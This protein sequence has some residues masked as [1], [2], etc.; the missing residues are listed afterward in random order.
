[1]R[2]RSAPHLVGLALRPTRYRG[3][4]RP[5]AYTSSG[6]PLALPWPAD[7]FV[8]GR[9]GPA[10]R[11][12]AISRGRT[13]RVCSRLAQ[14]TGRHRQEQRGTVTSRGDRSQVE[15]PGRNRMDTLERAPATHDPQRRGG[16]Q[17]SRSSRVSRWRSAGIGRH[18]L[19]LGLLRPARAV[20][21]IGRAACSA[22]DALVGQPMT[23]VGP[24][25]DRPRPSRGLAG[26]AFAVQFD[27]HVGTQGGV[28]LL[29]TDPLVQLGR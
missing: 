7:P 24:S 22:A 14:E 23:A 4:D 19:L 29:T 26:V 17:Y 20:G 15:Q 5:V 27:H 8:C 28:L 3:T 25:D 2:A 6:A 1:M 12:R 21:A 18:L 10:R 9:G 11:T 16:P 13:L